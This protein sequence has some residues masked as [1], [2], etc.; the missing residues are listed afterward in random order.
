MLLYPILSSCSLMQNLRATSYFSTWQTKLVLG[1]TQRETNIFC[2]VLIVF[3]LALS[4]PLSLA[5]DKFTANHERCQINLLWIEILQGW[6]EHCC[7]F[8]KQ[9][10]YLHSQANRRCERDNSLKTWP[11]NFPEKDKWYLIFFFSWCRASNVPLVQSSYYNL[12]PWPCKCLRFWSKASR[13]LPCPDWLLNS[14]WEQ[15]CAFFTRAAHEVTQ[16]L[17][18]CDLSQIN[19]HSTLTSTSNP[20]LHHSRN[21]IYPCVLYND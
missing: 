9:V 10:L 18:V 1:S 17:P 3:A 13:H 7:S 6:K 12:L 8:L 21:E 16:H 15:P 5:W 14:P 11:I 19:G 2:S 4:P 20:L